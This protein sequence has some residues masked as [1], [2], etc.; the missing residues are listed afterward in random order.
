MGANL[1]FIAALMTGGWSATTFA[2]E[3]RDADY[4]PLKVGNE[5]R[6]EFEADGKTS[7]LVSRVAKQEEIDGV[8]LY[9]IDSEIDSEPFGT[10]H[11]RVTDEGVFRCRYNGGELDPPVCVIKFPLKEGETWQ[12]KTGRG[13]EKYEISR[14]HHHGPGRGSLR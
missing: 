6:Y 5:W 8:L 2:A 10:E 7:T 13:K 12:G 9:R 11:L 4:Y 3:P 1:I 14:Q